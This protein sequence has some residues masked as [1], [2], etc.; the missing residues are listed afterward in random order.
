MTPSIR[1]MRFNIVV[2]PFIMPLRRVMHIIA[3]TLKRLVNFVYPDLHLSTTEPGMMDGDA[4]D[5][6]YG[7]LRKETEGHLLRSEFTHNK[8]NKFLPLKSFQ[9]LFTREK[10]QKELSGASNELIDFVDKRAK[11]T[12]A[13]VLQTLVAQHKSSITRVME[14]FRAH[15]F[16]DTSLPIENEQLASYPNDCEGKHAPTLKVFHDKMLSQC[17]STFLEN[18]WKFLAPKFPLPKE[19]RVLHRDCILPFTES[20]EYEREGGFS[21]VCKAKLRVDHLANPPNTPENDQESESSEI[22]VAI[23]KFKANKELSGNETERISPKSAWSREANVMEEFA[24]SDLSKTQIARSIGAFSMNGDYYIIVPWAEGGT[25]QEFWDKNPKPKLSGTLIMEFLQQYMD[26]ATSLH[27]LHS[28]RYPVVE[29]LED[30]DPDEGFED[31]DPDERSN[32]ISILVSQG[33]LATP[34]VPEVS[35]TTTPEASNWRHGDLKPDN[36]LR[37]KEGD[38]LGPLMIGDFGLAK[39]HNDLTKVRTYTE[40]RHGTLKYEP[41]EAFDNS[42]PKSRSYDIWSMGCII[43]ETIIWLLY[44]KEGQKQ[45]DARPYKQYM[46]TQYYMVQSTFPERKLND[47]TCEW[48]SHILVNDPECREEKC[49]S[50][51][52]DL[53]NL[54]KEELLVINPPRD[55]DNPGK[56]ERINAKI[57]YE[58]RK[59]RRGSDAQGYKP[60]TNS[61]G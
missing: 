40:T 45:F 3:S 32:G 54:A 17:Y 55:Y 33:D 30:R 29:R 4:A 16:D 59:P 50:A 11:R 42:R 56:G 39:K 53:L 9:S 12:F 5:E 13:T 38:A 60:I 61:R 47:T 28:H 49:S 35:K 18:Q 36:I 58:R 46:G 31:R 26:I 57:L 20:G 52:R 7:T 15:E 44:G 19:R 27:E 22:D 6:E 2:I 34:E 23:K 51:L 43:V 21:R 37:T 10:I 25:L 1:N 14:S 48:I 8:G 24:I 41:P